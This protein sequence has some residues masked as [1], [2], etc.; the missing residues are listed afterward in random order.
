MIFN[1]SDTAGDYEQRISLLTRWVIEAGT[2]GIRFGLDLPG[3]KV[4][5]S[6]DELQVTKC[7][8]LLALM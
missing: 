5:V 8:Q 6:N 7:L 2:Q 4:D 3:H 1:W